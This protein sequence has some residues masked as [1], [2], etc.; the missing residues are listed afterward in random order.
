[1]TGNFIKLVEEAKAEL[2]IAWNMALSANQRSHAKYIQNALE[3]ID[4]LLH[5]EAIRKK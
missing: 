2:V 4:A 1:M 5:I 3:Q